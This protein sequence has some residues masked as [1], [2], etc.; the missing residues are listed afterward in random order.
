M[1]PS[2]FQSRLDLACEPSAIRYA[3]RHAEVT[4]R[5]WG[6]SAEVSYDALTIVAELA[7]NA[8]RHTGGAAEPFDPVTGE[9]NSALPSPGALT[10]ARIGSFAKTGPMAGRQGQSTTIP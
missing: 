5:H 8:V 10:N 1:A 4:L 6:I 3:R 7:T 2:F 9:E